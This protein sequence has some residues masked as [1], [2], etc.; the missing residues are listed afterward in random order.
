[1]HHIWRLDRVWC[2]FN[3]MQSKNSIRSRAEEITKAEMI[4]I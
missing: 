2:I 1:M 3:W 4:Y